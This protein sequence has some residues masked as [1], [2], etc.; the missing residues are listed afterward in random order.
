M[1]LVQVPDG[2]GAVQ[3][4]SKAALEQNQQPESATRPASY[5]EP[6]SGT[7][8]GADK[9]QSLARSCCLTCD[10]GHHVPVGTRRLLQQDV[11]RLQA[12]RSHVAQG[13]GSSM[14]TGGSMRTC[15]A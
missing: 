10:L 8:E 1:V 4:P 11:F 7:P 3:V 13:A 14:H 12:P 5:P 2:A 9:E 15:C 6:D